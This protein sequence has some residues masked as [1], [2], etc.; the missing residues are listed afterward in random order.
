MRA[1]LTPVTLL[2]GFLDRRTTTL[3]GLGVVSR[4]AMAGVLSAVL[5]T[6]VLWALS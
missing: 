3:L 5:W 4:L 2:T 6:G 1:S